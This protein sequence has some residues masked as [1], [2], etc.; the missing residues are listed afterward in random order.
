ML[1]IFTFSATNKN[2]FRSTINILCHI[3]SAY[4][5]LQLLI[6]VCFEKLCKFRHACPCCCIWRYDTCPGSCHRI[7]HGATPT[8]CCVVN[9]EWLL[10]YVCIY[11]V[12]YDVLFMVF[13]M[14]TCKVL[15][16]LFARNVT[17]VDLCDACSRAFSLI[18]P[19]LYLEC[20]GWGVTGEQGVYSP[21]PFPP[22]SFPFSSLSS[23]PFLSLRSRP[24]KI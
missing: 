13:R 11:L 2:P 20:S 22:L 1:H 8:S 10:L 15:T 21:S 17:V 23:P 19:G 9:L 7:R 16:V 18:G 4:L 12:I 6:S 24:P 5:N 3:L 14:S